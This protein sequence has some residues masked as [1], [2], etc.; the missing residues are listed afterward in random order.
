MQVLNTTGE[1]KVVKSHTID[2]NGAQ[3][4]NI[5]TV[6]GVVEIVAIW[7]VCTSVTDATT[8]GTC[9]FDLYDGTA[10]LE[11]TDNGGTN[12]AGITVGSLISRTA[13]ATTALTLTSSAAG[14]L[15]DGA[16]A[17]KTLFFPIVLVQK[18][19][20]TTYIRFNFTG[21]ANTN[22]SMNFYVKYIPLSASGG[23][24]SV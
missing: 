10:P 9:Y 24:T 21:D 11:I 8:C 17:G 6:S 2:G 7:G 5:F 3:N 14:A 20:V 22:I 16:A 13:A 18:N 1:L 23:V 19:A 4:D 12:L 15:I